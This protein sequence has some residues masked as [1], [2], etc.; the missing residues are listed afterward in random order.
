MLELRDIEVRYRS[1]RG[2]RAVAGVSLQM[3]AGE[4]VGLVGESG[5]GK[6][7]VAKAVVGLNPL[8]AGTIELEGEVIASSKR[9]VRSAAAYG[10]QLVFQ[11][12]RASLNPRMS[13]GETLGESIA[14]GGVDRREVSA[15]REDLLLR[16][17]LDGS[18]LDR[19]PHQVSGGQ[20]QRV[21]IARALSVNPRYLILD[22]VTASLDVSVQA[23]ILNLLRSLQE[24]LGFSMLYISHDLSVIRYVSDRVY[25]MR[26]GEIVE[27][28]TTEELFDHPET[29][30]T[31]LL[32]DSVPILGGTR[33][34][35]DSP[36]LT[37]APVNTQP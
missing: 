20:L 4:T 31:K 3:A 32:L 18:Y 2:F 14:I 30:Y 8:S 27:E 15:A 34:R 7:S 12:P 29:S 10:C 17:G 19:Y 36:R 21:A 24:E 5:S 37:P 9:P 6:S 23:R 26:S 28:G 25:V 33:W 16:V 11:D 13:I 35:P 1:R 22:E